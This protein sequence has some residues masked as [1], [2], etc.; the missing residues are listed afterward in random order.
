MKDLT[1]KPE[2]V[3]IT[4]LGNIKW[5][6]YIDRQAESTVEMSEKNFRTLLALVPK[7]NTREYLNTVTVQQ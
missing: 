1:H 7:C 4:T 3:K 6:N 2:D 5:D